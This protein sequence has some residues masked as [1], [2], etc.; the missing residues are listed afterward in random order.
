MDTALADARKR[1]ERLASL[2]QAKLGRLVAVSESTSAGYFAAFAPQRCG[3][4]ELLASGGFG[5]FEYQAAASN[6]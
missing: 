6:G 3:V 2:S 1:A 4:S 5:L